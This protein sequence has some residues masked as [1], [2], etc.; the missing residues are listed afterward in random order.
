MDLD[1]SQWISMDLDGSRVQHRAPRSRR[2]RRGY[3]PCGAWSNTVMLWILISCSR[4]QTFG[5][6]GVTEQG[7]ARCR[8]GLVW[9]KQ[10]AA[11]YELG[12][13]VWTEQGAA[14]EREAPPFQS[15]IEKRGSCSSEQN[16]GAAALQ[17]RS[18]WRGGCL[19]EQ[20]SV[21]GQ[22]L[23]RAEF[24]GGA[25]AL[26]SRIRW[27]DTCSSEQN[28][29]AGQLPCKAE[30]SRGAAA[31]QSRI[32]WRGSCLAEQNRVAGQLLCRTELSLQAAALQSSV[33]IGAAP[34]ERQTFKV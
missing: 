8:L 6:S 11:W 31:L 15:R 30:S 32:Q 27:R 34:L 18:R 4:I 33:G 10:G 20:N 2:P 26:Q 17:S 21:V 19:A 5:L 1:G 3:A 23:F 14:A 12:H 13:A 28:S 16:G 25:A 7:A 24:S 9:T 22:L 29:V